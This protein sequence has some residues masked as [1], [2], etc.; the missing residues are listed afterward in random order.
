MKTSLSRRGLMLSLGGAALLAPTVR[1]QS[2]ITLR[3]GNAGNAQTLSNTFNAKLFADVTSKTG[4][5]VAF[6]IFAGTLGGEQKLLESMAL[7][8]LDIYN[9]AYTGTRE[10]DI[11]YSPY[12]FR[13]GAQADR[14]MQGEIGAKASAV[15]QKRYRARLLGTGRLGTYNLMLKEPIKSFADLKGRKIRTAAIEGCI[16]GVKFFGGNPTPIPFDQI[17]LALQQGIVDG[18]LTALNPGVAG[19]FYEV[20]KYV[21]ASDFGVALDKE[22]ISDTAWNRL[23]PDQRKILADGFKSLEVTDY[24]DIG[25]KQKDADLASWAKA[26]GPDSV[27]RLDAGKLYEELEP[28]NSR[29]ANEVFGPGAWDAVKKA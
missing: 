24:Y 13:D 11:L 10:F 29:L 21:V 16:E 9:G 18:V 6:T 25:L 7:G 14:V 2:K 23:K 19:K 4:G 20:C 5:A 27:I 26:N 1:A 15:L 28:L 8:S 3:Y 12:F 22:V 17:Y